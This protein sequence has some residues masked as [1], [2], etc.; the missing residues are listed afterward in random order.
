MIAPPFQVR[1]A[2][3]GGLPVRETPLY[4][5]EQLSLRSAVKL[6]VTLPE[7]ARVVTGFGKGPVRLV[8]DGRAVVVNDRVERG[9]LIFDRQID[10]PAGRVQPEAY[11]DFQTFVRGADAAL[12]RE[13][14]VTLGSA[15]R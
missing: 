6:R 11:A 5:S 15:S 7:G 9:V 8:N 1:L 13:I 2:G 3:F 10:L 4:I 12:L 14:V